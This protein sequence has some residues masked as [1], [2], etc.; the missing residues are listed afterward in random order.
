MATTIPCKQCGYA[1]ESERIY[2]HNCGTKLDRTLIKEEAPAEPVSRE[3]EHRR[4]KKIVDP[5]KGDVLRFIRAFII[6]V[7]WAGITA[8]AIQIARAPDGVP[9]KPK[10]PPEAPQFDIVLEQA[11]QSGGARSLGLKESDINAYLL[12]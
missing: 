12:N 9:V 7:L 5:H 1:N 2:C 3:K 10:E 11:N 8:G 6:T 4:V